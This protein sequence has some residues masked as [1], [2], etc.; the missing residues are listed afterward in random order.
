MFRVGIHQINY[1]PW[2]GYFNKMAKSDLFVFL[3]EV[4]LADRGFST[5]TPIITSTGKNA[6]L[7]VS[8]EKRGHREKK[9]SEILLNSSVDWKEKQLNFIKG[10]YS[11]C[12]YYNETM[13]LIG[14]I[15]TTD[16]KT[17]M[18]VNLL[19]V[20]IIKD[21]FEIRT[22]TILQSEVHYDVN[23]RKSDLMLDLVIG[24]GG[25]VYLSGN[26]ARKYMS[27]REFND[28]KV[29]VQYLCFTPFEYKQQGEH[30][31]I[32]GLSVL[33]MLFNEGIENSRA[34]FWNNMQNLE[35]IE[36]E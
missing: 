15:F 17:L 1:F 9:F 7:S 20:E 14:D 4:Q 34:L 29:D 18:D 26:G 5:R 32:E 6:Y 31:F 16:F 27:L 19:S 23:S 33:D 28:N 13:S 10:N 24:C 11:K 36:R 25:D 22:R 30:E 2:V 8:V 21:A 12:A 3:D 35:K